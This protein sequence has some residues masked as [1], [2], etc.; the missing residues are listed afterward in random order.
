M[1]HNNKLVACLKANGKVLREFKD[2]IYIPYGQEFSILLKNLNSVR[3]AVTIHIDGTEV[4]EGV[5][6]VIN[7]NSEFE[8]SRFITSGNLSSGNKFKFIERTA[9]IEQHR[10]IK[11]EDGLL[12]IEFQFEKI[13]QQQIYKTPVLHRTTYDDMGQD[14]G[15]SRSLSNDCFGPQGMGISNATYGASLN[16]SN[17]SSERVMSFMEEPSF[18]D[19]GITVA[20]SISDQQFNYTNRFSMED[21]KHVMVIKLL[22]ESPTGQVIVQPVTVQSKPVCS[23]CGHRNKATSKFCTDCGT[24]L[25]IV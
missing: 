5:S 17:Y 15:I 25:I 10:G 12:R 18:N 2:T 4:T 13:V 19:A 24:S 23:T 1:M 7:P 6:L 11:L 20:G 22:G 9:G 16:A 3:A 14:R 8:L 21:E